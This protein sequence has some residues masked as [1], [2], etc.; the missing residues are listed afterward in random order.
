M[1]APTENMAEIPLP[2]VPDVI[3]KMPWIQL[4]NF[5]IASSKTPPPKPYPT[6]SKPADCAAARF[7][8]H[9]NAVCMHLSPVLYYQRVALT[10]YAYTVTGGAGMLA[11]TSARALLE[12]GLT[13]LALFD[14]PSSLEKGQNA[15]EALRAEF[16]SAKI[17]KQACDVTDEKGIIAATRSAKAQLGELN[18][19]CCF[20]GMVGCIPSAEQPVDHWRKIIDVNTTGCWI[21]AQ[22][23]GRYVVYNHLTRCFERTNFVGICK[24]RPYNA[25]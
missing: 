9:G 13:G 12:H 6:E 1:A 3:S 11:L 16:P 8:V 14:L 22:A 23:V 17:I 10:E 19:L 15:I 24:S 5:E 21:A 20:A 7:G 25:Y 4:G 18:I 2:P